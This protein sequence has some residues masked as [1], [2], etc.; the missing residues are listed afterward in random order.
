[1]PSGC[2]WHFLSPPEAT[3]DELHPDEEAGEKVGA[4]MAAKGMTGLVAA[5]ATPIP[6]GAMLNSNLTRERRESVMEPTSLLTK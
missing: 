5:F 3:E 4:E 1:M 6:L 2:S